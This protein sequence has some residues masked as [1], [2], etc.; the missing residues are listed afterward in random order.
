MA[1]PDRDYVSRLQSEGLVTTDPTDF[2]GLRS[3][4]K[5]SSLISVV[6]IPLEYHTERSNLM[7]CY[8]CGRTNHNHG[9]VGVLDDDTA[10][11]I[12]NCCA[13]LLVDQ[14]TLKR[15]RRSFESRK[16]AVHYEGRTAS[17]VRMLPA[18]TDLAANYEDYCN[19]LDHRLH[20]LRQKCPD[21]LSALTLSAKQDG[22]RLLTTE[23]VPN[24]LFRH[25]RGAAKLVDVRKDLGVMAGSRFLLN[26]RRLDACHYAIVRSLESLSR[27]TSDSYG[28]RPD[29]E[30][31]VRRFRQEVQEPATELDELLL[32]ARR[33]FEPQNLLAADAWLQYELAAQ[34]SAPL[35]R[36]RRTPF[37]EAIEKV[38]G[39]ALIAPPR[40][41]S[42]EIERSFLGAVN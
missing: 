25:E 39:K 8:V 26:K 20:R 15:A 35:F 7:Y 33:F 11:L 30:I 6:S 13:D 4:A 18:L 34:N 14:T 38:C 12:G 2:P 40:S 22:A 41:L 19:D 31:L 27:V 9:F 24:P 3:R 23:L 16:A 28:S 37:Q 17:I 36:L 32:A 10:I 42:A 1:T 21:E 5:A 29:P